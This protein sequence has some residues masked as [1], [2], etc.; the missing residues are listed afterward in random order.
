MLSLVIFTIISLV[1]QNVTL[2]KH[3]L[4]IVNS[5]PVPSE[6]AH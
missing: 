4:V 6:E 5:F 3:I 1:V 2:R